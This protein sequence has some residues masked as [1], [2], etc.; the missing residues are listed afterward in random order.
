MSTI[1]F[2]KYLN[3]AGLGE[4]APVRRRKTN[5]KPKA[6]NPMAFAESYKFIAEDGKRMA[7]SNNRLNKELRGI[8]AK[9]EAGAEEFKEK[10]KDG[11]AK[12]KKVLI[13][14]YDKIIRFFT[15]TVRYWM[16]NERKIAKVVAQLKNAKKASGKK[17][18]F[19]VPVSAYGDI[20]NGR[21]ESFSGFGEDRYKDG[22]RDGQASMSK[23]IKTKDDVISSQASTISSQSDR[24]GNLEAKL[25][26]AIELG[27]KIYSNQN[28]KARELANRLE[29]LKGRAKHLASSKKELEAQLANIGKETKV[30]V[31]EVTKEAVSPAISAPAVAEVSSSRFNLM[32][33]LLSNVEADK[34]S[35]IEEIKELCTSLTDS[36]RETNKEI[37]ETLKP[38]DGGSI[39]VDRSN[40]EELVDLYI[41]LLSS[42][43]GGANG[44]KTLNGNIRK[45]T[46]ELRALK[47][48]FK[49][50]EDPSEE[51]TL[52]YQAKRVAIQTQ[53]TV[54]NLYIGFNDK[55]TGF[56]VSLGGKVA[57]A[58]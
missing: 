8:A 53:T 28:A 2:R 9:G 7:L 34:D 19:S 18:K 15:E 16:S 35:K 24:I 5:I 39:N 33:E 45:Y 36:F 12:V 52:K 40:Y 23:E 11:M 49:E 13:E 51:E 55:I 47:E 21:G 41:N 3:A 58:A 6:F 1:D 48:S 4:S 26:K 56:M 30:F 38:V 29:T 17:D 43:R 14:L 44:M 25:K 27:K 57:S 32:I 22:I 20:R 46:A 31:I 50:K 10:F 42:A 37:I 54:T